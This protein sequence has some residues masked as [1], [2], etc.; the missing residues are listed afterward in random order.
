MFLGAKKH[1]T[2]SFVALIILMSYQNCAPVRFNQGAR[3]ASN[4][5]ALGSSSGSGSGTNSSGTSSTGT[6][7]GTNNS[8]A[9][10]N[11]GSGGETFYL[12]DPLTHEQFTFKR[13][14]P[15]FR[16]V[17]FNPINDNDTLNFNLSNFTYN[18]S[19]GCSLTSVKYEFDPLVDNVATFA[20]FYPPISK[21]YSFDQ[22]NA[23]CKAAEIAAKLKSTS[24]GASCVAT[25][26]D[27]T[28]TQFSEL[29]K[30][31]MTTPDSAGEA[32]YILLEATLLQGTY[33]NL[34]QSKINLDS[35]CRCYYTFR[36]QDENTVDILALHPHCAAHFP[37]VW[38]Y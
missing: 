5:S 18:G 33:A 4:P 34:Q 2:L 21:N 19:G 11:S 23:A 26:R 15:P 32:S 14:N 28:P 30:F 31:M 9:N 10:S 6:N 36:Y 17:E 22:T 1:L 7:S 13:M 27:L 38:D 8:D 12:E 37:N 25:S 24:S 20:E 29:K 35:N 16:Q 3:D